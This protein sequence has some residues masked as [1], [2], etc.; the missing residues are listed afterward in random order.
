MDR[1][2][3][4]SDLSFSHSYQLT[5]PPE[6]PGSGGSD[7]ALYYYPPPLG[8]P[9]H[10]GLWVRC[11]PQSG[12]DWIGVFAGEYGSPPAISKILSTPDPN[13]MCVISGGRGYVINSSKPTQWET[14]PIFPITYASSAPDHRFLVFG[15]FSCLIAW[16]NKVVWRT[17]VTIDRL[18]V[19]S[20][21]SDRIEGH[22]Y[23]PGRGAKDPFV[24]ET[25]TGTVHDP[26]VRHSHWSS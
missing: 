16:N 13:R 12:E 11:C 20:L 3:F 18:T 2:M 26:E 23:D 22:G 17:N 15:T 4:E 21:N 6:L 14:I 9:E 1:K 24:I 25:G 5:E 7:L 8:R 10:D 19:T